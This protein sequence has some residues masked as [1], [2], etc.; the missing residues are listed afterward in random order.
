VTFADA[1]F[2]RPDEAWAAMMAAYL[3]PLCSNAIFFAAGVAPLKNATQFALICATADAVDAADADV[4]DGVAD[5][6]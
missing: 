2:A 5:A 3:C 1:D 4:V 6:V